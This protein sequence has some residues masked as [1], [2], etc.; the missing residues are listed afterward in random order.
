MRWCRL[1]LKNLCQQ[2]SLSYQSSLN[3]KL[4]ALA[5]EFGHGTNYS[6]L[7]PVDR[8]ASTLYVNRQFW[9]SGII[10]M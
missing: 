3:G 1:R 7:F 4:N 8:S 2:G 9:Y 10:R 5:L 6:L